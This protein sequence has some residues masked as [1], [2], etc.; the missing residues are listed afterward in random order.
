M[1]LFSTG[2]LASIWVSGRWDCCHDAYLFHLL[3]ER[4]M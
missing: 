2:S 1:R 4:F 3:L